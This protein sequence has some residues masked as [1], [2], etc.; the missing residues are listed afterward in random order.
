LRDPESNQFGYHHAR[1]DPDISVH[2]LAVGGSVVGDVVN[3]PAE[4]N[5]GVNFVGH[6]VHDPHGAFLQPVEGT[7]LA[8]VEALKP[9]LILST[10]LFYNDI[11]NAILQGSLDPAAATDLDVLNAN[12]TDALAR[13][14]ATGAQVFI[15]NMPRPG[16]LPAVAD[17]KREMD[18]AEADQALAQ[19]E[20]LAAAANAHLEKEAQQ[21]PDVHI[22]DTAGRVAEIEHTGLPVGETLLRVKK[23]GGLLGLDGVHFTNTGY[24]FMAN[25]FIEAVNDVLGTDV[26]FVDVE[27]VLAGDPEAPSRLRASELVDCR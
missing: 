25:L 14:A 10:D 18:P 16:L 26:P 8:H 27:A 12:T 7:Q 9:T 11:G 6:L 17:F 22:V 23:L 15:S 19:I 2:N 3:G 1:I 13:L 5:L 21:Y 24:A 20:A 4:D